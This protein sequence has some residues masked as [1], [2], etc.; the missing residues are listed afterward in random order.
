MRKRDEETAQ[1]EDNLYIE[2]EKGSA[3]EEDAGRRALEI[4]KY[5]VREFCFSAREIFGI[6]QDAVRI[7]LMKGGKSEY[8]I[9]E[10]KELVKKY[11]ERQVN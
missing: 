3:E 2:S 4:S 7:A 9:S 6:G 5:T 10:A 1:N 8:T 11:T